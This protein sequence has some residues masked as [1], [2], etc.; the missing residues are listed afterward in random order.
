MRSPL[1][2][3][4]PI[5]MGAG[6]ERSNSKSRL[7]SLVFTQATEIPKLSQ[8]TPLVNAVFALYKRKKNNKQKVLSKRATT[9]TAEVDERRQKA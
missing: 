3:V 2:S 4:P 7:G 8:E 6:G 5:T 1:L 9:E